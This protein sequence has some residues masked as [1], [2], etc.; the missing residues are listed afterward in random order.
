MLHRGRRETSS[1][2]ISGIAAEALRHH[3][4]VTTKQYLTTD[5]WTQ[6]LFTG[7]IG[8]SSFCFRGCCLS[9]ANR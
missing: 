2:K 1:S 6:V 5:S 9:P 7:L 4:L 8:S 3:N